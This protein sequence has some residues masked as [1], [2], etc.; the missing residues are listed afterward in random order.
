MGSPRAQKM[1]YDESNAALDE[2]VIRDLIAARGALQH[3]KS[4]DLRQDR[5]SFEICP[6]ADT[7]TA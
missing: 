6:L 3:L 4:N 2:I 7:S 1:L 5:L